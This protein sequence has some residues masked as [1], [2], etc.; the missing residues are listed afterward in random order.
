MATKYCDHGAYGNAVVTG[1]IAT[2]TLTVSARTSGQLG[3]GSEISG[4]GIAAGTYIT[5]LGTG[6]GGTGTYT[7]N[8][9]QTV[10]STTI[11]GVYGQP[12][13]VPFTWAEPQEGDG[14][15][16]T[17]ATASAT[18]S[19]DMSTWTFTS[20]SSTF[21]VMGCTA[22]TIGAGANSATNAQYNA[23]YAT[24]LANI[25]AAI[26]LATANAINV[27]AGVPAAQVRNTVYARVNGN[28]LEL[29]TRAGSAD[30]NSLVALSFTNVTGSSS[31][32]WSGGS[33]GCW[34]YMFHQRATMWPS[35]MAINTYGVWGT[36]FPLAGVIAAG[37]VIKVRSNKTITNN[38]N[39]TT[40][41]TV[42]AMGSAVAPVRFD[43]DDG[44]VWP[45]DGSTPVFKMTSAHTTNTTKTISFGATCY[46]H[47]LGKVYAGGAR[48]MVFEATGNGPNTA[49]NIIALGGPIKLEN[50][51]FICPGTPT[52]SPGPI[53]SCTSQFQAVFVSSAGAFSVIK[54][55]RI[56]Q[57]GQGSVNLVHALANQNQKIDFVNCEFS[58]T[59]ASTAWASAINPFA[60][61]STYRFTFDSCTFSGF[62]AGSRLVAAAAPASKDQFLL[63]KNC[64]LGG[65]TVRG[66]NY[67]TG[68]GE[69]EAGVIG[70]AIVSQY[71]YRE[72]S[73]DRPGRLYAE[74]QYAKSRPTLNAKL[75]D[76]VTP[77]SIF[78]VPTTSVGNVSKLSPV[79]L[80]R[81]AKIIPSNALLTE[82]ARTFTV[83]FLLESTLSWTKQDISILINYQDPSG[84]IYSLDT[85]DPDGGAL[86]TSTEGWSATSWNG[87]TW[88]KK[89]FAITTPVSVKADSEVGIIVRLHS[90]V[91]AD[92]LGI[93]LDPE[94]VVA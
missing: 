71:G 18:V 68:G 69:F 10:A 87:Q 30:Y 94:I 73:I 41:F 34:G 16:T 72:F 25:R 15:A 79:E 49:T 37:D 47:F 75:L 13:A 26:N 12:L 57:P 77:W 35:A 27:P 2:T 22:L 11:T 36:Q 67:L 63:L 28:N 17:K 50:W 76:G 8:T 81:L 29:M 40:S 6:L 4:T 1:S 61:G 53:A 91:A 90:A 31:Q 89:Q 51:E 85:Y 64:D 66:P 65:I 42:G 24:M 78:A 82:A 70:M 92:T 88:D 23:T 93:I 83:N 62:V 33:G 14:S 58:L 21:S 48:S 20:G 46:A 39:T 86:T 56:I 55:C 84:N 45:A 43:I 32:S 59:A 74:W 44:T 60:G 7:V 38:V 80:P 19:V 52:A 5:A 9:S 3:V 54:G